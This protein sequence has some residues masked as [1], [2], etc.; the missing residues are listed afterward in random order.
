MYPNFGLRP[1]P[2]IY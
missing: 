1:Q 2:A